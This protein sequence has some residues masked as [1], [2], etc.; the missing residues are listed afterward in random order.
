MM[1]REN[2]RQVFVGSLP[3]GGNNKVYIQSMCNTR[4]SDIT[5]TVNQII[6]L[7]KAGCEIIRVAVLDMNDAISIGKIKESIHIPLV[8]DIHFDYKLALEAINQGVDA[9]RLNPGNITDK[10]KVKEVVNA[11][12][13]NHIPIRIGVNSGSMP[14]DLKPTPSDM[15]IAV[16]RHTDIL[17]ELDFHDIVISLKSSNLKLMIEAYKLASQE[18]DYP[19]HVGLTEAGTNYGGL[20]K[21]SMGI[22]AVLL[23]GI[24]NTIR[25]S[26][27]DDPLDEV[28]AAKQ[29]LKN[30]DLIN[31]IPLLT[32]CP[33]CGR[34]QY[35]MMPIVH[36][37]EEYLETVHK[38]IHIAIMGCAV[39]GPGEA[40][41]ADIG[42][43]G[44]VNEALLFKKGEI[45]RK[46][47]EKDI[48]QEL[49]KEI[50]LF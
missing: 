4:T 41:E 12:K 7:E 23:E 35:N 43:A 28:K 46:I 39:N 20:I 3:L 44:G 50:D 9:I 18:F 34:T 17:E 26:L 38:D 33:T 40:R 42:I 47:N 6:G 21:G 5:A 30:C 1:R 49:K 14:K 19:L 10:D 22:G 36:E 16:K 37:I 48:I 15:I 32:S 29:I 31:N 45:I 25:V 27:T 11:C 2:T 13:I 8:A 24:G